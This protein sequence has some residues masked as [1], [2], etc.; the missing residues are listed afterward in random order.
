MGNFL[1]LI[2]FQAEVHKND[3]QTDKPFNQIISTF[4]QY[5]LFLG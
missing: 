5:S 3:E 2:E 4:D 1:R